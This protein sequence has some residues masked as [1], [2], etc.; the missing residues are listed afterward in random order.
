MKKASSKGSTI[1]SLLEQA[2]K[3]YRNV[4]E[5]EVATYIP[6]LSKANPDDFGICVAT[7]EGETF[8][9]GDCD[10]EFTM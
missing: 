6:E 5:G 8:E 9:V 1:Q 7:V 2:H 3:D 4:V 10:Q